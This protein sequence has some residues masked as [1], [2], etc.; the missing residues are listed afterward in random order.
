MIEGTLGSTL[1]IDDEE[2]RLIYLY[3][4]RDKLSSPD[5]IASG[6][7]EMYD[8][9]NQEISDTINDTDVYLDPSLYVSILENTYDCNI[10]VFTR[11]QWQTNATL[12]LPR[13]TQLKDDQRVSL[14][15]SIWVVN[16][17]MLH[18]IDAN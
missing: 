17:I 4:E 16:L 18:N 5:L 8:Y 2:E 13:F 9:T 10:Y 7:Q 11:R 12:T 15:I 3:G 1:D 6:K 14:F